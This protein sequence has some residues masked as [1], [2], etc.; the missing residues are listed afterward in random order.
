MKQKLLWEQGDRDLN[1]T[2]RRGFA[3]NSVRESFGVFALLTFL[4]MKS[5]ATN[6]IL[7]LFMIEAISQG[8]LGSFETS[9]WVSDLGDSRPPGWSE[10]SA[11]KPNLPLTE[12]KHSH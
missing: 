4:Q 9:L 1:T 11:Q 2:H 12:H 8:C 10:E 6:A 7:N 5:S 3:A